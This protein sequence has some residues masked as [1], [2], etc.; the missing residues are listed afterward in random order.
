MSD[1]D[2][3]EVE[4]AKPSTEIAVPGIGEIINLEDARQVAFGL[5]A[6]RDLERQLK[7]IKSE[8]TRALEYESER[9]GTKTLHMEGIKAVLK[10]GDETFYD[11]EEI[12]IGL[13]EAG[14]PED[15]IRLIVVET[16][17]YKV[18]AVKAKQAAGANPRY[19]I[20]INA[21]KRTEPKSTSVTLTLGKP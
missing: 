14:M 5:D 12:E 18:D 2:S 4:E 10:S 17:T 9:V 19:A 7:N 11:A 21:N 8:L 6:V 15:R 3:S 20:V 13:R 16:T 1:Q